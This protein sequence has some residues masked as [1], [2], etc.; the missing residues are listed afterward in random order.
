MPSGS[1]PL[2]AFGGLAVESLRSVC[3]PDPSLL[4]TVP[5]LSKALTQVTLWPSRFVLGWSLCPC[6]PH[7]PGVLEACGLAGAS[8]SVGTGLQTVVLGKGSWP[9][10]VTQGVRP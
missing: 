8:L 7:V 10:D 4:S 3:L 6:L 2:L 5:P 1:G 9:G